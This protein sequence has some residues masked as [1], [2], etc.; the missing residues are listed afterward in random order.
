[1]Q[2]A[3][4]SCEERL[5]PQ[6]NFQENNLYRAFQQNNVKREQS[7]NTSFSGSALGDYQGQCGEGGMRPK[8]ERLTRSSR[9]LDFPPSETEGSTDSFSLPQGLAALF[10][11]PTLFPAPTH[12]LLPPCPYRRWRWCQKGSGTARR[13][14]SASPAACEGAARSIGS[15]GLSPADRCSPW[16]WRGRKEKCPLGKAPLNCGVRS[17]L[18]RSRGALRNR[19]CETEFSLEVL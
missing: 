5:S 11:L 9:P 19:E 15:A 1:M 17:L 10:P 12:G 13:R 4:H 7:A 16:T 14:C 18:Q 6:L 3:K 8:Q 2:V